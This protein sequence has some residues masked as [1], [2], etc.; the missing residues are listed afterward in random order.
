MT[1]F[2][3]PGVVVGPLTPGALCDQVM[4]LA[5]TG[6]AGL[7]ALLGDADQRHA[8]FRRGMRT[9]RF[10]VATVDGELAGY[11]SLKYR[12][13][14]PFA[15]SLQDFVR[16]YGLRRGVHAFAVFSWIEERTRSGVG[17]AYLYGID[18]LP[19][20]RGHKR[21]PPH[22]VGGELYRAAIRRTAALGFAHLDGEARTPNSRALANRMGFVAIMTPRSLLER[23]LMATAADYTRLSFTIP[24]DPEV[25]G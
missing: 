13:R 9:E 3:S 1:H 16:C 8:L 4:D 22:G 19:R 24:P 23:L 10:L 17:G 6:R 12:G 15:P 20:F 18:I 11:M 25:L 14:G 5:A 7:V 2:D 21:F